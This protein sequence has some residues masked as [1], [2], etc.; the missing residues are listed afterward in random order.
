MGTGSNPGNAD[1]DGDAWDS[2]VWCPSVIGTLGKSF[3][4]WWGGVAHD[5]MAG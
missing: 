1:D 5:T 3:G 2:L 4:A